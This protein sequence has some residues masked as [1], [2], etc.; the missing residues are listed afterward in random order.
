MTLVPPTIV[1]SDCGKRFG[2]EWI[3]RHFST[4]ILPKEKVVVLGSNGSG[5]STLLQAIAGYI[6]LSEG[7]IDYKCTNKVVDDDHKYN[8]ISL[9]SPYLELIEEY[10]LS[11]LINHVAIYKPFTKGLSSKQVI[12]LSGLGVAEN[13]PIRLYSSGMK[14][15]VKL[16]L[17]ILSSS[18]ILL[19]DEPLSNLDREAIQWFHSLIQTYAIDKTIIVCSN[20]I[21]EEYSF[22]IRELVMTKLNM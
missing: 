13:K 15:R 12:E 7:T 1:I 19:L 5:K 3:F 18:P 2:K 4:S 20:S 21:K 14:Q 6:T 17:A 11:E 10:T 9:S 8:Y 16:T 22:C